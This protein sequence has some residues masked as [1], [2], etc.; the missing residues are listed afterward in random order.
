MDASGDFP[1]R[2]DPQEPPIILIGLDRRSYYLFKGEEFLNQILLADGEFPSPILCVHFETIFD[3]KKV[4]G[5]AFSIAQCWTIHPE[6]FQRLK[7]TDCLIE[8]DA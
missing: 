1:K 8:T 7:D 3:A 4:L 5:D 2:D 6:I